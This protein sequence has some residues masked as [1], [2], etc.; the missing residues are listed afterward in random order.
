MKLSR[1][2]SL[3]LLG[4]LVL[5]MFLSRF[6]PIEHFL[7]IPDASWAVFFIGGFY[8]SASTRWAF[9]LLMLEAVLID[10]FAVTFMGVSNFCITPSYWFLIPTH[11]VMWFGGT[12]LHRRAGENTR[13][14]LLL[15]AS[16]LV[17]T[18]LAYALSNGGFYWFGG[19]YPDPN[20]AQYV[21]RFFMYYGW[22]LL[23]PCA[24][25]AAAAF[26]HLGVRRALRAPVAR[27]SMGD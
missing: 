24:Y 7:E 15:V 25:I 3:T 22:F 6:Q 14:L 17:A 8:L 16:A 27:S 20:L 9:P 11:A 21:E 2:A 12:W 13:G 19:R 23:V 26:V 4:G 5:L 10:W 18:T 1:S